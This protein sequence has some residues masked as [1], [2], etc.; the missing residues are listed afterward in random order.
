MLNVWPSAVKE[1]EPA[2]T[3][4]RA[5]HF[6]GNVDRR[7]GR[8]ERTSKHGSVPI[9]ACSPRSSPWRHRQPDP[10]M[11]GLHCRRRLHS[12][13]CLQPQ[14]P[15]P[16]PHNHRLTAALVSV[17]RNRLPASHLTLAVSHG[18]ESPTFNS[19]CTIC[20][21]CQS[22]TSVSMKAGIQHRLKWNSRGTSCDDGPATPVDR[23]E[24]A[25]RGSS[26]PLVRPHR[27]APPAF[28]QS[29][30]T[31]RC[32]SRNSGGYAV[33]V[34]PVVDSFLPG[35]QVSTARRRLH[36]HAGLPWVCARTHFLTRNALPESA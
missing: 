26:G 14:P 2:D 36:A 21:P 12:P 30:P 10:V 16:R 1:E 22:T 8:H 6:R 18:E 35:D 3:R 34:R 7:I 17:V 23:A 19:H 25:G 24:R 5:C 4:G 11:P 15:R 29:A 28:S 27:Q 20:G 33:L 31:L 9:S 32:C 13:R